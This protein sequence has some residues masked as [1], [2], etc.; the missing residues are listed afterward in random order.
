[1]Q[2]RLIAQGVVEP[3]DVQREAIPPILTGTDV[4]VQCYTGSGKVRSA[5]QFRQFKPRAEHH[6]GLTITPLGSSRLPCCQCQVTGGA[7]YTG[8]V[9]GL[10][11]DAC[12]AML[13]HLDAREEVLGERKCWVILLQ[14]FLNGTIAL[15]R[16]TISSC[17]CRN[18]PELHN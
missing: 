8:K 9:A 6:L 10:S 1:M 7:R 12:N 13:S 5:T 16:I 17:N 15:L 14:V 11:T 2:G 4:A 18:A 3:T